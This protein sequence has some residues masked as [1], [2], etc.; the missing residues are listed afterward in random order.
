[1]ATLNHKIGSSSR[2]LDLTEWF[3]RNGVLH[4]LPEWLEIATGELEDHARLRVATEIRSHYAEAVASHLAAGESAESAQTT[5]LAE[6]GDP[7][8]AARNLKRNHLT[9]VE[10][11][12]IRWI[13]WLAAKPLFSNRMLL[14]DGI[15]LAALALVF[16]RPGSDLQLFGGYALLTYTGFRLIPR[17][18][19]T[20][21]PSR[22]Y[23]CRTVTL[24]CLTTTSALV[25]IIATL[26]FLKSHQTLVGVI[27]LINGLNHTPS[28]R[29]WNKLRKMGDQPFDQLPWQPT[30]S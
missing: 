3:K 11:F 30:A 23:F 27:L 20:R 2:D 7:K 15:S 25:L 24:S 4:G 14:V 10:V 21:A 12:S 9:A 18:L 16:F 6:L 28:L 8:E 22:N 17:L 29:T 19:F 13:E 1:M 26:F 5:A